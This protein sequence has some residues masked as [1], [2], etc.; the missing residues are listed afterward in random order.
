MYYKIHHIK[1]KNLDECEVYVTD[2]S[3]LE[4]INIEKK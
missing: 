1:V 3:K 4:F 2:P